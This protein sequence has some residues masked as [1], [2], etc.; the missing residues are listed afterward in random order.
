M[1]ENGA[2]TK[3]IV[4]ESARLQQEPVPGID[5]IVDEHNPRYFKVII[6]GPSE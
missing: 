5:A 6:D 3:R 4:K 2:L 1:N